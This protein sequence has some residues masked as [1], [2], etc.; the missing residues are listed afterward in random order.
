M[1]TR[2]LIAAS[3][4]AALMA[5]ACD[6]REEGRPN[7][8]VSEPAMTTPV[9]QARPATS[10]TTSA[11]AATTG[12]PTTIPPTTTGE[13]TSP[14]VLLVVDVDG[15]RLWSEAGERRVLTGRSVASALSDRVGGIVFQELE[16][17]AW[18]PVDSTESAAAT[19]RWIGEGSPQPIRRLRTLDG[20]D[21]IVVRPPAD[22]WVQPVDTAIVDGRPTLAYVRTRYYPITATGPDTNPWWNSAK[23][24]LV[25]HDLVTGH[26]QVMRTQDVGWE[27]DYRT[28]SLGEKMVAD[29]VRDYGGGSHLELW[30]LD[31]SPVSVPYEPPS[32]FVADLPPVGQELVYA[33]VQLDGAGQPTDTIDVAVV[34]QRS[35]A[36]ATRT[37]LTVAK[38]SAPASLDT[39]DGR[40]L[41][42]VVGQVPST[43][44]PEL[45]RGDEGQ[46]V[47][48]VQ[49]QLGEWLRGQ[50]SSTQYLAPDGVFG[51]RTEAQVKAYQAVSGLPVT[52]FVD[53][54]TWQRLGVPE[55]GLENP[56][57]VEPDGS[58]RQLPLFDV[59][60]AP[61]RETQVAP[62]LS[63]NVTITLWSE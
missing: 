36:V 17:G 37:A 56:Y 46:W 5:A 58:A 55:T 21:E 7:T 11:S 26:E 48:V 23:A 62:H 13:P 49:E 22:G 27:F 44:P 12:A 29:S 59:A 61:V 18:R 51:T 45:R 2:S 53:A 40:S 50:P 60:G 43:T 33:A 57:L 30:S 39:V 24:E 47:R 15:V 42:L 54:V 10:T 35:G 34:D 31:G 3:V 41:V 14:V 32:W 25:V 38:E 16:T 9:T 4:V 28:P 6:G 20:T 19:W 52:G 1:R 63:G 8:T